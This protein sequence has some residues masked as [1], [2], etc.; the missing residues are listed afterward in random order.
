MTLLVSWAGSESDEQ[1]AADGFYGVR[2]VAD[3]L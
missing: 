1:E 2:S 3:L